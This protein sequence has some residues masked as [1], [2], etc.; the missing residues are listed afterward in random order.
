MQATKHEPDAYKDAA[1]VKEKEL[2][3]GYIEKI[4]SAKA[5]GKK[6]CYTFVPGGQIELLH[7]FDVIPV[8]PE[9]LGLQMGMRKKAHQYIEMAENDGYS[10]DICSYVKSSVGMYLMDN[11]GP[12]GK[13]LPEPDFLFLIFSQCFTFMKWWEILRKLFDCPI[14]TIHLPFRHHDRTTKE[15]ARYGIAQFEKV[16]IPQLEEIT[17]IKFDLDKLKEKLTLSRQMEEELVPVFQAAKNIP[18]PVDGLFQ[19]LY[20]VGPINTYFRGTEEG[21]EFYKLTRKVVEERV[22]AKQGPP[23]PF[24]R[25]DTQK[26]RLVQECGI[27]WDNFKEYNKI[28]FDE[29]AVIVASTYTKVCGL[30]DSKEFMH[31][32][33]RPFESM[34]EHNM[35]N[36][37]NL[38]LQ[39]RVK[40][41]ENYIKDYQADGFL[42][43]SLKSCKSFAAGQLM[44][45]QELEKRTGIPG[46]FFELD[47]MDARYFSEANVRTRLDSYFR[48][49]DEKRRGSC[50]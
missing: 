17:G 32:P 33:E 13:K 21:V 36:Y 1:M 46:A 48:M 14:I 25:M 26:Y 7:C 10:D 41:M 47:M 16:V 44:M 12:Y 20:Y 9:V 8:F 5:D 24:G 38:S 49:I 11:V 42:V 39:D 31:D 22:A 34:I 28:L 30:Y 4:H 19:S 40:I 3:A 35:T 29:G 18:C 27:T 37:C 2:M 23:T 45:L 6:I 50:G 15:E 43:G